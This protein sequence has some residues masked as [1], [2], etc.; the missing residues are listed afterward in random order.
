MKRSSTYLNLAV[1]L[2]IGVLF[3]WLAFR[4]VKFDELKASL[5]NVNYWYVGLYLLAYLIVHAIRLWRWSFLLAPLGH[6]PFKRVM[7]VGSVGFMAIVLL[8][9]RM[10]EL[11]RPY[12]IAERG[13]IRISS[14]LGTVAVERIVDGLLI[15][16]LFF[17]AVAFTDVPVPDAVWGASYLSLAIFGSSL[18]ALLFTIWKRELSNRIFY[19]CFSWISKRLAKRLV[20]ILNG[21]IDGLA[22]FPDYRQ[23][24]RFLGVTVLYWGLNGLAMLLMLK[25]FHIHLPTS[26]GFVLLSTLVIAIMI[27][28][29]PGLA[30]T[31]EIGVAVTLVTIFGI[32]KSVNGAFTLVL[33]LSQLLVIVLP[34]LLF[35]FSS[36]ISFVKLARISPGAVTEM[37]HDDRQVPEANKEGPGVSLPKGA[38]PSEKNPD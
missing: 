27:P 16:L 36:Q 9:F 7:S 34:G 15:T 4:E 28:G 10:G 14:V 37:E 30:G 38:P 32:D 29:A 2:G 11:V 8:P 12:L 13:K 31:F 19:F 21:F 23:L 1:S 6:V 33:H 25:A 3:C 20:G 26:A 22:V 5:S 17:V 35:L 18:T 24:L